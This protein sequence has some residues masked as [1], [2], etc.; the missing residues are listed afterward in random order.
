MRYRSLK[1]VKSESDEE[2]GS[3]QVGQ[4]F[5][6]STCVAYPP[7]DTTYHGMRKNPLCERKTRAIIKALDF[8]SVAIVQLVFVFGIT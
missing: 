3:R 4:L 7:V 6:L 1:D 8:D 5:S 2:N